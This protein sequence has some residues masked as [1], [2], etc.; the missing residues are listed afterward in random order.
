MC[1][2]W[3]ATLLGLSVVSCSKGNSNQS[4]IVRPV[5]VVEVK[6]QDA[7]FEE[8]Y[9]AQIE[10]RFQATLSFQVGGRLLQRQAEVGLRVKKGAVLARIDPQDLQLALSAAKAQF[11]VAQTEYTQSVTDLNRAKTLKGQNFVSQAELDRKQLA[12]EAASGR[13]AQAKS[14]L[15]LQSNQSAYGVLLAPGDGVI[16]RVY[17]QTGQILSPGQAV[18][19][20]AND[21]SVQVRLAIPENKI[22]QYA[23]GR[24]ATVRLWSQ[25]S[26]L[27]AVVREVS[28]VADPST[29]AYPVYLDLENVQGQARFGMSATVTFVRLQDTSQSPAY[30]LPGS[31][32]V[33]ASKGTYVWVFDAAQGKVHRRSVVPIDVSEN[34]FLVREGL[35][36]GELVVTAGTHVLTEGQSVRRFVEP[37]DLGKQ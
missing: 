27:N 37:G 14:Q 34:S 22:D 5:R 21:K 15:S 35:K 2:M 19:Q 11:N 31:A 10:P 7:Q 26:V 24:K 30:K 33:G 1:C 29:R 4:E 16:S 28:P 17:A 6:A 3:V 36:E 18:V 9:P 20:W 32:L 25:D 8:S 13:L 12:F 23:V